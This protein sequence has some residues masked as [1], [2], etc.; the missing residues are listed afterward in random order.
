MKKIIAQIISF[1]KVSQKFILNDIWKISLTEI[2]WHKK[3]LIKLVRTFTLAF[4]GFKEDKVNLRASALTFYS[5]LS[6]VPVMAMAF[7]IAKGFGFEEKMKLLLQENLKGQEEV[8]TF[9]ID[10]SGNMLNS[11]KGGWIF[12][13][14]LV[15]LLWTVMQVLGNIENAFNSIW[16][17]KRSRVFFRKFSDYF[18]IMLVAPILILVSSSAQIVIIEMVDRITSEIAIIG[19][20]G[21]FIYSLI[22]LIPFVLIWLLF[23]FIYMVMPNT[24][25]NFGSALIAGIVAGTTFQLLQFFY[26]HFQ[27]GVS[28][29]NAIYGS[30]AALPLFL[31]WLNWS[32]LIVLFGAE[33]SFSAQNHHQ[34]EFESDIKTL[35]LR[36]KRLT[37]LYILQY[38]IGHFEK[39]DPP[40][41]AQN[42]S[43][44]LKLPV[45]LVRLLLYEMV[46]CHVLA[47]T[48]SKDFKEPAFLPA[49]NLQTLTMH[50]VIEQLNNT[51]LEYT[52]SD[53]EDAALKKLV[54]KLDAFEKMVEASNENSLLSQISSIT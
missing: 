9:L 3:L 31:V 39:S 50:F 2:N 22:K 42:I 20:I 49:R 14:G 37:S 21:P 40:Q 27:I 12:G 47:E 36:S 48:P 54:N 41:T 45:R 46:E 28:K 15:F 29:Y 16:Q 51:G 44:N 53:N 34:Y 23:T 32:W 5:I 43:I 33:I 13:V 26:I 7:G 19:Y 35:S 1:I 30:F 17:V 25:V 10:F 4:R 11:V 8:A 18:S 24:K 6:V 38:I 52:F